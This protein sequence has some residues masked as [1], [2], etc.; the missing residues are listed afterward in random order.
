MVNKCIVLIL[1]FISVRAYA[2]PAH[3]ADARFKALWDETQK[4]YEQVADLGPGASPTQGLCVPV[5]NKRANHFRDIIKG[6]PQNFL[7]DSQLAQT[8]VRC[9]YTNFQAFEECFL[10]LCTSGETK[11]LLKKFS[12]NDRGLLEKT[13]KHFN[14]STNTLGHLYYTGRI[15]DHLGGK[16][17]E[18]VVEFGGGYGNLAR[19]FYAINSSVVYIIFDLPEVLAFQ[20]FFLRYTMPNTKIIPWLQAPTDND[21][22]PGAIH[23]IPA[24]FLSDSK[25]ACDVFVSNFAITEA[26]ADAQDIVI[27]KNFFDAKLVYITGQLNGWHESGKEYIG[28]EKLFNGIRK[29]YKQVV[30][31]P[32]HIFY[33]NLMSFELA[34]QQ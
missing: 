3:F 21:L 17:P 19:I 12:D 1:A 14:C 24:R 20:Y 6:P 27:C 29:L 10:G 22:A 34:A 32:F 31:F 5:W 30:C 8:M 25:I 33:E 18:K 11:K 2:E 4:I 13:A 23:L 26:S 7:A 16:S 15:L 28:H 9:G